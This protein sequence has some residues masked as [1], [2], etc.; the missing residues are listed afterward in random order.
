MK[1]PII[2]RLRI[3]ILAALTM[4]A[5]AWFTYTMLGLQIVEGESIRAAVQEEASASSRTSVIPSRRGEIFDRNGLPLVTNTLTTAVELQYAQ[6]D[7]SR[8][9]GTLR[10][11]LEILAARGY[12]YTDTLPIAGKPFSYT[13]DPAP[14]ETLHD[15]LV[16]R[17]WP[18]DLSADALLTKLC[19][20]YEIPADFTPEEARAV[21]GLRY[22]LEVLH[23]SPLVTVTLAPDVDRETVVALM[24]HDLPGVVPVTR[25]NREYRTEYMAHLLGRMGKIFPEDVAHYKEKGYALD[26]TVGISG[27]EKALEDMLHGTDGTVTRTYDGEGRLIG[28]ESTAA[29]NGGDVYLTLDLRIQTAAED[30]LA[31]HITQMREAGGVG[32][33]AEGGAAVVI[34]VGTAEVLA[35]A[36]YPTYNLAT[37]SEDYAALLEA[38]YAPMFNRALNGTYA[39]GSTYKMVTATA[40]LQERVV[41][42]E[43]IIVDQGIY[44]YYAPNYLYHCW[45]YKDYGITHGSLTVTTALQNSC[46]YFFYECGRLLGIRKLNEYAALLGLGQKTGLEL[47][48]ASGVLAGPD[49]RADGKWYPGDTLLAAIGQSDNLFTPVQLCNYVATLCSGGVRYEAHMVSEILDPVS[50]EVR[51]SKPPT[52][53]AEIS[54]TPENL[55]AVLEGMLRVTEDGTASK[56][57]ADYPVSVIGKTGSAQVETGIANGVFVL[58]APAENPRYAIAVIVEHGG[59]GNNV[60]WI[61]RDI[62]SACLAAEG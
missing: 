52:P 45:I 62:L 58:A 24:S 8:A 10:T 39:P 40:A 30:A 41:T 2:T 11:A 38:D 29:Q 1:D 15:Y 47:P 43:T 22:D 19:A 50:G 6:W 21:A 61:A 49:A 46:N 17:D 13:N 56:V 59:S 35:A 16:A 9:S 32:A 60:A 55:S 4:C 25:T 23:F 7:R 27:F 37:F 57:F 26:A 54:Y 28:E 51:L 44:T 36:R 20:R 3:G 48:E 5:A 42:P 12:P 34:E 53:V 31:R 33:N 18:A 14:M